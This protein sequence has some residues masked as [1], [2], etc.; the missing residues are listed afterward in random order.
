MS[1]RKE[2]ETGGGS[3]GGGYV[4]CGYYSSCSSCGG[5]AS[6]L[7]ALLLPFCHVMCFFHSEGGYFG[8][9]PDL[10]PMQVEASDKITVVW[11]TWDTVA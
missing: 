10:L 8:L 7:T 5:R 3:C 11:R 4:D 6:N 2:L 9:A 1:I